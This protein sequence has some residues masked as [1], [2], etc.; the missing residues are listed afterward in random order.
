MR[1]D[2]DLNRGSKSRPVEEGGDLRTLAKVES[3]QVG[4]QLK[5]EEK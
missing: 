2:Q 4:D 3:T 1:W 5:A